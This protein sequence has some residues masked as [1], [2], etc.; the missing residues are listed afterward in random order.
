MLGMAGVRDMSLLS[1]SN[2]TAIVALETEDELDPE[3]VRVA[4]EQ[5]MHRDARVEVHNESTMVVKLA[6]ED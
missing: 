4:M 6:A 1:Y 2:G 5:A 3:R